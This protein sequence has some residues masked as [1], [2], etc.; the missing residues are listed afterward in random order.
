MPADFSWD[1]EQAQLRHMFAIKKSLKIHIDKL[2]SL[3][4]VCETVRSGRCSSSGSMFLVIFP[5]PVNLQELGEGYLL[6]LDFHFLN[7]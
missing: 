3:E 4:L 1:L 2:L 5:N 7:L 6:W